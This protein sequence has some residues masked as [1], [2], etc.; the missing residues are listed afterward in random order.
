MSELGSGKAERKGGGGTPQ[1]G[2]TR[3]WFALAPVFL[4]IPLVVIASAVM[5]VVSRGRLAPP[6]IDSPPGVVGAL[7]VEVEPEVAQVFIDQDAPRVVD[8]HLVIPGM[9]P[10]FPHHV[11][12]TSPGYDDVEQW[13]SV[14]A[15][16]SRTLTVRLHPTTVR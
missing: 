2:R 12:V 14:P 9:D 15:H 11:R 1:A 3:G 8:R 4:P 10:N 7:R 13:V 6:D 5:L 16:G